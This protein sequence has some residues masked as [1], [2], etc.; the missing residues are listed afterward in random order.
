MCAELSAS[1][2]HS[3]ISGTRPARKRA[4]SAAVPG[5]TQDGTAQGQICFVPHGFTLDNPRR[6]A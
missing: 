2:R 6:P 4:F 1:N 5:F 3:P